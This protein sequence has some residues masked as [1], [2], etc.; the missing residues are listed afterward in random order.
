MIGVG[1]LSRLA[2]DADII[3]ELH[4]TR[5]EMGRWTLIERQEILNLVKERRK[6]REAPML[7]LLE[8]VGMA[9]SKTDA[10]TEALTHG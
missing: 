5:E 7:A 6:Q 8:A 2:E 10:L 9:H 1:F 4:V 3:Q